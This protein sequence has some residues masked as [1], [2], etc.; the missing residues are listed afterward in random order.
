[1]IEIN[2]LDYIPE[3]LRNKARDSF[4]DFIAEQ[5]GKFTNEENAEKIRL[6]KTDGRFRKDFEIGL[7]NAAERFIDEYTSI[8]S[9]FVDTVVEEGWFFKNKEFQDN[10]LIILRNPGAYLFEEQQ[11]VFSNFH[12]ILPKQEDRGRLNRAIH[13]FLKCIIS[14]VMNMPEFQPIYSLQFQKISAEASLK[15]IE[16]QKAQLIALKNINNDT[17]KALIQ[18]VEVIEGTKLLVSGEKAIPSSE[19]FRHNLPN[20]DYGVFVGREKEMDEI[21]GVLRPYPKSQHAIVT[22]DGVGGVGKSALA[23]E[24]AY[25]YLRNYDHLPRDERFDA[26]IWVSAKQAILTIDG[27]LPR[28]NS[29]RGIQDI[30]RTIAITLEKDDIFRGIEN[31]QIELVRKALTQQR[32]LLIIDNL[33]SIDD[34]YLLSFL[35]D[36]PAPTKVIITTRQRIDVAYPIRLSGMSWDESK[37]LILHEVR[38]KNTVLEDDNVQ[39]LFKSTGGVPLAIVWSIARISFGHDVNNVLES[40]KTPSCDIS[41]YCFE[42]ALEIID[43]QPAKDVLFA[44]SLFSSDASRTSL[45]YITQFQDLDRDEALS[46]LERL[47]LI[48]RKG[49]RFALLPLTKGYVTSLINMQISQR[50]EYISRM[51]DYYLQYSEKFGCE[52]W[53]QYKYI[54]LELDNIK[55]SIELG[56]QFRKWKIGK[57]I[58]NLTEYLDKNRFWNLITHYSEMALEAGRESNDYQVIIK[59]KEFG[60]GWFK[61]VRK[62]ELEAGIIS[63]REAHKIAEKINDIELLARCIYS[64]GIYY[65]FS[66]DFERAAINL[67][68]S[69][70]LWR[71]IGNRHWEL[72]LVGTLGG[73]ERDQENYEEACNYYKQALDMARLDDNKELIARNLS[74]LGRV[75][76]SMGNN[77]Q[78]REYYKEALKINEQQSF[79]YAVAVN[80]LWLAE[81]E[82]NS[83]NQNN[84]RDYAIRAKELFTQMGD[85]KNNLEKA[86]SLLHSI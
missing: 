82:L 5:A 10:L 86:V 59:A 51:I 32:V 79:D 77:D 46:T 71:K 45:G 62:G 4:V 78:A 16:I 48:N 14:E 40:L 22:I 81:V 30:Y 63:I 36:I 47:S 55:T 20:P 7:N 68:K 61:V 54:D 34:P 53:N 15:Q 2:L 3:E 6:L 66:G 18:L 67:H 1:M 13:H 69:L 52:N 49:F 41:R 11:A 64:E 37:E 70:D 73:L 39:S 8:D 27:I 21:I 12:S 35:R 17:H 80:C 29:L 85:T 9:E 33:E 50:E 83:G 43:G 65:Q 84:G 26:I 25:N 24:V 31:D 72:R 19:N 60:L 76:G 23:M 42:E 56:Y 57:L 74:R 58:I 44:L 75:Q 38:K 28:L